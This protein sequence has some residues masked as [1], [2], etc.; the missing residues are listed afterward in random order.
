MKFPYLLVLFIGVPFLE[1][2]I[3]MEVHE[4]LGW[5]STLGLIILTGFLG[6]ALARSQ[7]VRTLTEIQKE[8]ARGQM[9]A[10]R[11]VDGLLILLAGAVLITP[12]LLTD[13]VG[14]ALLV[15][16]LRNLFRDRLKNYFASKVQ[17]GTIDVQYF[18]G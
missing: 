14:F 15:P 17:Q 3:L 4:R 13:V 16:Q 9:P 6:A 7:G 12:G 18:E 8:L 11:L 2:S 10:A 1:L 5:Q